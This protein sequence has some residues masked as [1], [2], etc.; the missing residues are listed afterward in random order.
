MD[1]GLLALRLVFGLLLAAHGAQKLFGS[2]GGYGPDGTGQFFASL[3]F[4]P[5]KPMA[6]VAGLSE[7]VGG[8]LLALG[9]LNPLAAAAVVG[10]MLVAA[11]THA[12][13]G[14]WGTNGGYEQA[15]TYGVAAA[16][17]AITGPGVLSL[18]ALLGLTFSP[19]VGLGAVAVGVLSGLVVIARAKAAL[20]S[21][22]LADAVA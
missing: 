15:L 10:T 13:K 7:L 12:P 3:G 6:I 18:D 1:L 22:S 2:F 5:G 9:L 4:R 14:L 20:R 19:V 21:D 8:V 16:A 11:S 17:L